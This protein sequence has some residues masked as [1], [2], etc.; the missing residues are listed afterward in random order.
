MKKIITL[1]VVILGVVSCSAGN[2][3]DSGGS[4]SSSNEN[5]SA[6]SS[7]IEQSSLSSIGASSSSQ[8]AAF[9]FSFVVTE[10]D[11][12]LCPFGL[13]IAAVENNYDGFK[14]SGFINTVNELGVTLL[15]SISVAEDD[16]YQVSVRY[17]NGSLVSRDAELMLGDRVLATLS[18]PP[19][20][21]WSN[22]S[23]ASTTVNLNS[24]DNQIAMRARLVEGL[25]NIDEVVFEGN[26]ELMSGI[27]P[28]LPE[29]EPD[30]P[31]VLDCGPV[32]EAFLS[33]GPPQNR[34][35]YIILGDGYTDTEL[36]AALD[37]HI[38]FGL[39]KRF[40]SG[41]GEPFGRYKNFINVCV[42]KIASPVSGVC[43]ER[44]PFGAC[45]D[46]QSRLC[47]YDRSAVNRAIEDYLPN[48]IEADW[49]AVVLNNDRWW[50]A[51]GFP[52][53]WSGAH[54]DADGAELH[55]AGHAFHQLAD[56]Y[57]GTGN[58]REYDEVN[59]TADPLATAGKWDLWMG[60]DQQGATGRQGAFEGSR[61]CDSN[62]Y[63]PSNNSMMNSLFGDNPNTS[64]NSVSREQIIFSIWRIIDSPFDNYTPNQTTLNNPQ[65]IEVD[66]IDPDVINV[67][68]LVDGEMA[69]ENGG[70][71]FDLSS[72]SSGN[73]T[74]TAN[75]Y[76]NAGEDLVRYRSGTCPPSNGGRYCHRTGWNR[77]KQSVSW[78]VTIP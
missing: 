11:P 4:D 43:D 58:C 57:G 45:G 41:I 30:A 1:L 39:G 7:P 73:Y 2:S 24:G 59:S 22:W 28:V 54:R 48:A 31:Y 8:D 19:T 75:A 20:D 37:D 53:C 77:S 47:N 26:S 62:Q 12:A 38:E 50:N 71:K 61:Y 32:G 35:N 40:N 55:E 52:M 72:L 25:P 46:D 18:L 69:S 70:E 49:V 14:D 16:E 23:T 66:V 21:G 42:L 56:E 15:I 67:D 10:N 76:D 5:S 65:S 9:P 74:I 17:A 51:G 29:P 36:N 6:S 27:C 60:Y 68:W 78:Q 13:E 3:P 33:S 34:V 63:R 64:F 44:T